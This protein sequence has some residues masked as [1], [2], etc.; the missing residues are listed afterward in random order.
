VLATA[1]PAT[2]AA[3]ADPLSPPG[4]PVAANVTMTSVDLSW[5]PSTGPVAG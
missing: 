4:T 1:L 2:A 3:A 5:A